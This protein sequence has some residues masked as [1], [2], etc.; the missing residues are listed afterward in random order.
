MLTNLIQ[1]ENYNFGVYVMCGMKRG[2]LALLIFLLDGIIVGAGD[3]IAL[4]FLI[5]NQIS[6]KHILLVQAVPGFILTA[7]FAVCYFR[8]QKLDIAELIGEK[9]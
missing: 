2:K 4:F 8:L 1:E 5:I 3:A 7:S 6:L 9:E